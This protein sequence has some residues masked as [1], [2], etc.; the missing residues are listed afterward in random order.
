MKTQVNNNYF[1]AA[2]AD[3]SYRSVVQVGDTLEVTVTDTNGNVASEK[4]SF[5]V[6]PDNLLNAVLSCY[7]LTA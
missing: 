2:T 6:T 1:A 5:R 7:I 3:I 4:F